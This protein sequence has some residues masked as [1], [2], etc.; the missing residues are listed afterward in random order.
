VPHISLY[1]KTNVLCSFSLFCEQIVAVQFALMDRW[2]QQTPILIAEVYKTVDGIA[3]L[4]YV[5]LI[6]TIT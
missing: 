6:H 1:H 2:Q 4:E 5:L 3:Q